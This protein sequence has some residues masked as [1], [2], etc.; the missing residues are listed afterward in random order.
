MPGWHSSPDRVQAVRRAVRVSVAASAGFYT[1]RY[2]LDEPAVALYALFAPIALGI[3][4]QIPGGG[5]DRALVV[6]RVL[7]IAAAL[8]ALGTALAVGTLPAVAGMLL[9]GFVLA[10]GAVCGPAPAGVAPGL[11]LF[12]ILACFPPYA[13][14]TLPERLLGLTAGCLLLA[15]CE[16]RLLPAP[17]DVGYRERVARALDTAGRAARAAAAAAA[18]RI[19][20]RPV[21]CAPPGRPCGCPGCRRPCGPPA[22][23]APTGR[24]RTRDRRP[25]DCWTSSRAPPSKPL[26]RPPATRCRRT[27]SPG[28]PPSAP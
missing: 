21:S 17:G 15:L 10:F 16:W 3:L 23:A 5:R 7:P 6:L 20:R 1:A 27:W 4:S 19:P 2:L 22:R 13:P 28:S 25:G 9:V 14:D 24:W 26:P 12:Y 8:T 11:L 18:R